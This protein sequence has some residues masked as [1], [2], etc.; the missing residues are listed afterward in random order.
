MVPVHAYDAR[1]MARRV[2]TTDVTP[3]VA[4][5]ATTGAAR[6]VLVRRFQRPMAE[7]S[8]ASVGGI[9]ERGWILNAQVPLDSRRCDLDVHVPVR[10]TGAALLHVL[11]TASEGFAGPRTPWGARAARAVQ[12][13]VGARL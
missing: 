4:S 3:E 7:A 12:G 11:V 10:R 6:P 13:A 5:H 8:T 2:G 9:G 1:I